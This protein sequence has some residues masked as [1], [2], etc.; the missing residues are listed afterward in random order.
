MSPSTL[1]AFLDWLQPRA[2]NGTVV[3]TVQQVIGG[4]TQQAVAGPSLPAA[5]NATN[6]LRNPSLEQDSD[7][8]GLPDCFKPNSY[9]TQT[10]TWTRT[11]DAHTGTYAERV[12]VSN[13]L[14]G[15]D[16][17]VIFDDLGYCT[18]TVVPGHRY[19]LTTWY[20]STAPVK[21]TTNT[22]NDTWS[23]PFAFW[24]ES[25][26]FP[27]SSTWTQASWTTPSVPTG[28]NGLTFGLQISSNGSL[29]VDDASIVDAN[30]TP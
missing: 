12:D 5:P 7:G 28:I 30:P 15:A 19:T 24:T 14:S 13:Y 26:Q 18:P 10:Y 22:R 3:K 2:A 29:T 1:T 25:P 17:F 6:G 11:T 4:A 9:G 16:A 8:D 20:K 23:S 27:A 21:F